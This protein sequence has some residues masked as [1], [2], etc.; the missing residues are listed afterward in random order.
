MLELRFSDLYDDGGRADP[1]PEVD[2][3]A[4]EF[5]IVVSGKTLYSEPHMTVIELVGALT[6][7][8]RVPRESRSDFEFDSMSTDERGLVWIK[9]TNG[10]YRIGSVHQAYEEL[11]E[12]S[13]LEIRA[14]VEKFRDRLLAAADN[15]LSFNLRDY[16]PSIADPL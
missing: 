14:A 8:L 16:V 10:G 1:I 7:W 15:A 6:R 11:R 13:D 12:F 3:S 4:S 2:V 5:S 9:S